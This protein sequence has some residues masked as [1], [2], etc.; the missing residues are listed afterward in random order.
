MAEVMLLSPW[1]FELPLKFLDSLLKPVMIDHM[2][3]IVLQPMLARLQ[4]D[5]LP[6][7]FL[8]GGIGHSRRRLNSRH[9]VLFEKCFTLIPVSPSSSVEQ[10]LV[11]KCCDN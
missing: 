3:V 2:A 6:V 11:K 7:S 5:A 8:L 1:N 9:V 10:L 4:C